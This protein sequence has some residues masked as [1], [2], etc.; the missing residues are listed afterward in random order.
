MGT[1]V[2]GRGSRG[3]EGFWCYI[4]RKVLDPEPCHLALLPS[5][6][7]TLCKPLSLSG[8]QFYC[9]QNFG[10][11]PGL[12]YWQPAGRIQPRGIFFFFKAKCF[13]KTI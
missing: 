5:L 13:T 10:L 4:G 12:P 11:K 7:V 8:L 1:R 3:G 9:L 2:E 6:C